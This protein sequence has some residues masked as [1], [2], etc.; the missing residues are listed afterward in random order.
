MANLP[1]KSIKFPGLTDVYTIPQID[2]QL[3]TA[4]KAADAKAT[5]DAI[6][7]ISG[8][9]SDVG[10]ELT[11][12]KST[13]PSEW[14]NDTYY[15]SGFYLNSGG[16]WSANN[17]DAFYICRVT[18][19]SVISFR[20]GTYAAE[21]TFLKSFT[22]PKAGETPDYAASYTKTVTASYDFSV[23]A[24]NDAAYLI[25]F[26]H[27]DGYEKTP[28]WVKCG[29]YNYLLSNAEKYNNTAS[30]IITVASWPTAGYVNTSGSLVV[31]GTW[32][33]TD[34]YPAEKIKSITAKLYQIPSTVAIASFY[35]ENKTFVYAI[36]TFYNTSGSGEK[37]GTLNLASVPATAKYVRFSSN[38]SDCYAVIN[39]NLTDMALEDHM[40][41]TDLKTNVID[42][43]VRIT[44][45]IS[46]GYVK[47]EDGTVAE[48][49]NWVYT[50]YQSA[51]NVVSISSKAYQY[52]TVALV[53][54]Y[55]RDKNFISAVN[56]YDN[57]T[58][59]GTKEGT[60]AITQIPEGAVF[61]R[62]SSYASIADKYVK[63]KYSFTPVVQEAS[64]A[65]PELKADI[66]NIDGFVNRIYGYPF[67]MAFIGDSLTYG[68]TYVH[69]QDTSGYAYKN[70]ANYPDVFCR[71]LGI[72]TNTVIAIPGGNPGDVWSNKQAEIEAIEDQ[73][74]IVWLG[75]NG[76]LTDS[77][78]TDCVGDDVD[79][80]ANT[81]TGNYGKIIKTLMDNG[82][83]V[84]LA[85]LCYT[86][87]STASNPV[88]VKLAER[89]ECAVL[90]LS[91]DDIADLNQD[92]FHTAYN[93]YVNSVH[94]NSIGYNHVAGVFFGKMMRVI[95]EHPED[96]ELFME[97]V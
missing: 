78:S 1:L 85:Q 46:N 13:L 20:A 45:F 6:A 70:K 25:V 4:G 47:Y 55:D 42:S 17:D 69:A 39:Y 80:Y 71:M 38:S 21:Y 34:Y 24:P 52:S 11:D 89:F 9:L 74:V 54:F 27:K 5:G 95:Y 59:T 22:C 60:I 23:T 91:A 93:G 68:S 36:D 57:Q 28:I 87:H 50:D 2:D 79:E 35:D 32:A 61:M 29:N 96:F 72:D 19:S 81:N 51:Q 44:N 53:A 83:K 15:L 58:G 90:E 75:T 12:V 48:G 26:K 41:V 43:I 66:Q 82:N 31:S 10:D 73:F 67:S 92:K 86:T 37:F 3:E 64:R 8:G 65:I 88:I 76:G 77:V 30:N 18:P 33:T 56:A 84:F 49:E 63:I 16:N 14:G 97:D 40:A 94:F 7:E 62:F